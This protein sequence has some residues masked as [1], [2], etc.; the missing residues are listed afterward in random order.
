[1]TALQ[2]IE[3]VVAIATDPVESPD[4][5]R[6]QPLVET[7]RSD[8]SEYLIVPSRFLS[9]VKS[10][11][12]DSPVESGFVVDAIRSPVLFYT[13]GKLRDNRLATTVVGADWS[14][15]SDDE[16]TT[17]DK[18]AEFVRWA[19][20]V[21]QWVRAASPYWYKYKSQRITEKAERARQA[22]LE[23]YW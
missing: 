10:Y 21:M 6:W 22:G 13:S 4:L 2:S 1:M 3:P 12:I 14:Y 11:R 18:S 16:R 7:L 5:L 17:I 15:L 19:K 20:R 8:G 23:V 9:E